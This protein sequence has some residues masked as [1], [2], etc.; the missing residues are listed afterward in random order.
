MKQKV[1]GSY[2]IGGEY[3]ELVLREGTGG[4]FYLTPEEG[5]IPRIKVGADYS[6]WQD[7]LGVLI[8]EAVEMALARVKCRYT[9]EDDF[10][11][12]HL[13]FLFVVEHKDFSDACSRA[14]MFIAAAQDDL[15]REWKKRKAT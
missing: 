6:D 3:A 13:G 11:D 4:E 12:D 9:P 2:L 10:G 15:R 1:I 5:H 7:V 14:G 8:H